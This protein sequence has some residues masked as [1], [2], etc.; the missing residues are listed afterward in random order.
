MT[1]AEIDSKYATLQSSGCA[2]IGTLTVCTP[3]ANANPPLLMNYKVK[4]CLC[5]LNPMCGIFAYMGHEPLPIAEVLKLLR[6]LETEQEPSEKS[7]VGGHGAG[8]AFLNEGGTFTLKK[9]GKTDSSPADD[10][11]FLLGKTA[12]G[13]CLVLG[14]VRRASPEFEN[15]IKHREC[16]QPYKPSCTHNFNLISAHNGKVQNYLE[17]KKKLRMSHKFESQKT[18]LIDSEV[19]PHLFEELLSKTKSTTKATHTLFE[20]IE[21]TQKQGNTVAILTTNKKEAHLNLIQK[22]KTRGLIAWTNP[23]GEALI[24]SREKPIETILNKFLN[25]NNLQKTIKVTH[26]DPVNLETHFTLNL[27]PKTT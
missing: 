6:A 25:Q 13:S 11:S 7:P 9:V 20:V 26:N 21:G 2:R 15:T 12:R 24:C 1:E 16:T 19:I 22:G 3:L 4:N 10:L 27:N 8:I 5:H 17:L 14:H 23:K 18:K